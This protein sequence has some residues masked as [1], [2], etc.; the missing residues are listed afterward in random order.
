RDRARAG[1]DVEDGGLLEAVQVLERPL[2][3][4]LRLGSRHQGAFVGLERQ[5]PEAP[6]AEDVGERLAPPSPPPG[7]LEGLAWFPRQLPLQLHVQERP[8]AVVAGAREQ[9]LGFE[10]CGVDARFCEHVR[11]VRERLTDGHLKQLRLRE[12]G[13]ALPR[14]APP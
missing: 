9:E 13:A 4:Y 7:L 6:M 1:A 14:T 11:T 12:P 8:G 3:D 2:D 10:A 5:P